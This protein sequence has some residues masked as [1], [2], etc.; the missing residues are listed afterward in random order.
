MIKYKLQMVKKLLLISIISLVTSTTIAQNT[1]A[2]DST[3]YD[4]WVGDWHQ[5]VDGE[6]A[7][8]PR[9]KVKR[10][11]YSNHLEEEWQM[12]G[13]RAKA[14]RGWDSTSDQWVFTWVSELG[15]YQVWEEKKVGDHWYMFKSFNINGEEVLSRQAFL[16]QPD[17]TVIRT[18]EHSQDGGENWMLRFK[19]EYVKIKSRN[20][21]D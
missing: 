16:Q 12:E 19:E 13:Y 15:H 8:E 1:E 20:S 2:A 3:Y 14:W 7:D 6:M 5:I 11:L 4:F 10:G 18:S 9:F 21:N 17:G